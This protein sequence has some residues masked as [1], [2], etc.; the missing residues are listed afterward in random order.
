MPA[1]YES[2]RLKNISDRKAEFNRLKLEDLK[3][4]VAASNAGPSKPRKKAEKSPEKCEPRKSARN[5]TRKSSKGFFEISEK[6]SLPRRSQRIAKCQSY[7]ESQAKKGQNVPKDVITGI[8]VC[9]EALKDN[10]KKPHQCNE[11]NSCFTRSNDLK[12]HIE[13]VHRGLKPLKCNIVDTTSLTVCDY[14]TGNL[15]HLK[16]HRLVVHTTLNAFMCY[17]CFYSFSDNHSLKVHVCK[18]AVDKK[19][20]IKCDFCENTYAYRNSMTRHKKIHQE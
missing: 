14:A 9:Q 7:K 5:L 17:G 18:S 2:I 20:R 1:P 16:R 6:K 4:A 10:Y 13:R 15:S 19:A 12:R 11:C 8:K 3:K